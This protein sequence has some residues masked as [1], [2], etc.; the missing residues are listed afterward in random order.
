MGRKL[1]GDR[2]RKL[3]DEHRGEILEK[4]AGGMTAYELSIEYGV[5]DQTIYRVEQTARARAW[6]QESAAQARDGGETVVPPMLV[7]SQ[8]ERV[9]RVMETVTDPLTG[10][11]VSPAESDGAI[12]RNVTRDLYAAFRAAKRDE[13][14]RTLVDIGKT[15]AAVVRARHQIAPPKAARGPLKT[16]TVEASPESWPEPPKKDEDN[17]NE[18]MENALGVRRVVDVPD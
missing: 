12:C 18:R 4:L 9:K 17:G 11:T 15:I 10:A 3:T 5:S 2:R 6:E 13:D 1:T 14:Y 8:A 16:Y 7:K